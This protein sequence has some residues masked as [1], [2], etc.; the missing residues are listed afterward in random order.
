MEIM[1]SDVSDDD[2]EE[3]DKPRVARKRGKGFS[4]KKNT[5]GE[6]QLHQVSIKNI[7]LS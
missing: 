4:V 2:N 7:L 6:T 1:F 3:N 5:K